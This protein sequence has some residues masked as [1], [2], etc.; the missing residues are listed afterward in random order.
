MLITE[1]DFYDLGMAYNTTV[2]RENLVYAEISAAAGRP[3][4]R[5]TTSGSP[6]WDVER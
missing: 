5:P 6:G 1:T 3:T 4:G 2:A